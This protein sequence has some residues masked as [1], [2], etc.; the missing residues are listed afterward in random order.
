MWLKE[1]T[2]DDM[3]THRDLLRHKTEN[4]NPQGGKTGQ[5]GSTTRL[6]QEINWD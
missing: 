4:K 1:R 3:Q 2:A 5:K 6:K